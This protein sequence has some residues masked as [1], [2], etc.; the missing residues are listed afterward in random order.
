MITSDFLAWRSQDAQESF[1]RRPETTDPDEFRYALNQTIILLANE[2]LTNGILRVALFSSNSPTFDR[3]LIRSEESA[4][5][6]PTGSA[7]IKWLLHPGMNDLSARTETTDGWRGNVSEMRVFYKPPLVD[8]LPS[9][10]GNIF[11]LIWHRSG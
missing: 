6:V 3:F 9:F 1:P 4:G 2:R 11:R 8:S 7:T 10:R 5:W